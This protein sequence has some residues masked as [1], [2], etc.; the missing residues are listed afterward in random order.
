MSEKDVSV[1]RGGLRL[2]E[3]HAPLSKG[4]ERLSEG[5]ESL[6][7]PRGRAQKTAPTPAVMPWG[8][9]ET[10]GSQTRPSVGPT[11]VR[12]VR[13]KSAASRTIAPTA[14]TAAP[15]SATPAGHK[16]VPM[17]EPIAEG[18]EASF[19]GARQVAFPMAAPT[20]NPTTGSATR[21]AASPN[22][23]SRRRCTA[24]TRGGPATYPASAI[25]PARESHGR[26][27]T[28]KALKRSSVAPAS[29]ASVCQPYHSVV[30]V[31]L[32][33][34]AGSVPGASVADRSPVS[35]CSVSTEGF[36]G[37]CPSWAATA[38]GTERA[39]TSTSAPSNIPFASERIP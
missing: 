11:T 34:G 1:P 10:R 19:G 7:A 33:S 29:M 23:M 8:M 37:G 16:A 14:P 21:D 17:S 13:A 9:N 3:M 25:P 15:S 24:C 38:E 2:S 27:G 12:G 36:V 6:R 32:G 39:A 20:K 5:C 4:G 35:T 22:A 26:L 30:W 31:T 18:A 28:A